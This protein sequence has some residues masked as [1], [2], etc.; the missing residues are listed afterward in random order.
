MEIFFNKITN[1][2]Y[3]KLFF[4]QRASRPNEMNGKVH[5]TL[6]LAMDENTVI[7]HKDPLVSL[8]TFFILLINKLSY[9]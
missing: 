4:H 5:E 7:T 2:T 1:T 9:I 8:K 3:W 6:A